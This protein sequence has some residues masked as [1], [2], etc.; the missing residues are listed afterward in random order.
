MK[1][2][3]TQRF[4]GGFLAL[5]EILLVV[6]IIFFLCQ[7]AV[8]T[9]FKKPTVDKKTEKYISKQDI[10]SSSHQAILDSTRK[11]VKDL[12]KQLFEREKQLED[13]R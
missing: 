12:E 11:K 13:I 7:V 8:K 6:M 4:E 5:L 2:N 1:R 9:Y 3:W 10:D